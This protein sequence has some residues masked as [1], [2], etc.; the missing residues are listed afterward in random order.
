M[1]H[2]LTV[3]VLLWALLSACATTHGVRL[4]TGEGA[5]RE[6]RPATS[7]KPVKVDAD[8]FEEAL[9]LLVLEVPL[10]LAHRCDE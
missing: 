4:D 6:Y 5:P 2:R 3:T 9:T 10:S 8:A 7:N 1:A